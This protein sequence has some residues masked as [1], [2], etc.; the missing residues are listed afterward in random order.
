MVHSGREQRRGGEMPAA[1]AYGVVHSIVTLSAL[2]T[3]TE[4]KQT[5]LLMGY[6]A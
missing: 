6:E 4:Q 3:N 2:R 5:C 1:G